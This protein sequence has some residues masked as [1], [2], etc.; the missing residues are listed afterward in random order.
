MWKLLVWQA[1]FENYCFLDQGLISFKFFFSFGELACL[2]DTVYFL[3]HLFRR[4]TV[5][6]HHT[7]NDP[8]VTQ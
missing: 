8:K 6:G 3:L 4:H 1:H 7:Y 5:C 2:S